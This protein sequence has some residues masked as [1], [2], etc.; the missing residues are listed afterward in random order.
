MC[1]AST[2]KDPEWSYASLPDSNN[3][4]NVKC[5]FCS[6][7]HK[8]GITRHK[9]QLIGGFRNS[10]PCLK[11]SKHVRVEFREYVA[12]KKQLKEQMDAIPHFY[13]IAEEQEQWE[14]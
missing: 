14:A 10:K 13:D 11:C 1:E 6:K 5:N 4:N 2:G 3:T 9:Q 7:V 8:G 12:K